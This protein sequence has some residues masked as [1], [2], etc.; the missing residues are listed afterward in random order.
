[1]RATVEFRFASRQD[2][3]TTAF[4]TGIF[5]YSTTDRAGATT[6]RYVELE[7]LLVKHDGKWRVVMERQLESTTETAWSRMLPQH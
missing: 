6:A 7:A 5:K 2:D 3:A 4:E 1:M